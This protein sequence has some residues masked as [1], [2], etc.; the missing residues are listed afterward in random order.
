MPR[1]HVRPS[2]LRTMDHNAWIKAA[3]TDLNVN[4]ASTARSVFLACLTCQLSIGRNETCILKS[5]LDSLAHCFSSMVLASVLWKFHG[6][7]MPGVLATNS[8][9]FPNA[10]PR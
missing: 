1:T 5:K 10:L 4:Y 6:C 7:F 8:L 3:I 9:R 2:T